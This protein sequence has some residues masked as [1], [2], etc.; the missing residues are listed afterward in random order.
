M[1]RNRI[2]HIMTPLEEEALIF[3]R[4]AHEGQVRKFTGEPYIAHPV[5]V[6]R[7]LRD[8]E[9]RDPSILAAAL[10]HDVV[11]DTPV[12]VEYLAGRFGIR[13]AQLVSQ[14]TNRPGSKE[15]ERQD[16]A[17]RMLPDAQTIRCADIIAN[18]AGLIALS[19]DYAAVYLPKKAAI[20]DCCFLARRDI[21]IAAAGACRLTA[22][23][24]PCNTQAEGS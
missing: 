11:E 5:A 20:V 23:S 15:P 3:A 8:F 24:I 22:G 21:R 19:P 7:I 6:R 10:L 13:V 14:L 1:F 2:G 12:T 18:C 9:V 16:W 4:F 17:K